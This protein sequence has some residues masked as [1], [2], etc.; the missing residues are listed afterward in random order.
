[1]VTFST[2]RDKSAH[3]C[4]ITHFLAD[5][6]G[7]NALGSLAGTDGLNSEGMITGRIEVRNQ[8]EWDGRGR[9]NTV[10]IRVD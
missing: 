4:I 5:N 9:M 2:Q 6:G 1:M 10:M 8:K 7:D 3:T